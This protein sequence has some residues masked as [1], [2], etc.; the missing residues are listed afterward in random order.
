[1]FHL[2]TY[3][4]ETG[5]QLCT[6][7]EA[8]YKCTSPHLSPMICSRGSYSEQGWTECRACVDGEYADALGMLTDDRQTFLFT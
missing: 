6:D 5:S 1:M 4:N 3:A 2:G 8:G 7:C